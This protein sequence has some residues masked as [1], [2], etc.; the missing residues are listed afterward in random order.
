MDAL[1]P[2]AQNRFTPYCRD[3]DAPPTLERKMDVLRANCRIFREYDELFAEQSWIHVLLGRG[4]IP[5]GYDPHVDVTQETAARAAQAS[6][7]LD[8]LGRRMR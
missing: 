1:P 8:A 3:I 4:I 7:H 2:C 6:A 5:V